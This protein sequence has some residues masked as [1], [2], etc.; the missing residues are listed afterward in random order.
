MV[1]V[2]KYSCLV[3]N[4]DNP[5]QDGRTYIKGSD[6]F[7]QNVLNAKLPKILPQL[8]L[9]SHDYSLWLDANIILKVNPL[10]LI[11]MMQ[12]FDCLVVNHP[13]R[14]TINQEIE[15]C[16]LLDSKNNLDYHKDKPGLLA[17]CGMILR[18]N[19]H[20]VN[21][22]NCEWWSEI[23]R[24]SFRDQL[25][26]PYTLGTKALVINGEWNGIRENKYFKINPHK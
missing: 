7:K 9:E 11:E 16:K 12:G 26:F 2:I 19:T 20:A 8:Y 10:E 15:A 23:C 18:K 3:G 25:S 14:T 22:L 4:Y 21:Q 5:I 6:R 13:V 24:G 1:K 17:A